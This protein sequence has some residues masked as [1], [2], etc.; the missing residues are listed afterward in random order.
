[1][2]SKDWSPVDAGDPVH[3]P[4]T[5]GCALLRFQ[6]APRP[7]PKTFGF[8]ELHGGDTRVRIVPALGGKIV[9]LQLLGREWL[10]TSDATEARTP[11]EG[12]SYV[13]TA[14]TGG[15]DECFPTV[16]P[17]QL[18]SG[19]AGYGGLSLPDHGELWTQGV[20]VAIETHPEGQRAVCDWAGQRMPYRFTRSVQV[21]PA[22]AV[23]MRYAVTNAGKGPL[24]F[25]W[26]AHPLFPLTPETRLDLPDGARVRV[27]SQH[28]NA[29]RG[30]AG[31]FRWPHARLEKRLADLAMPDALARQYACK[32]FLDM[33][34]GSSIAAIEEGDKRLEVAFDERQVP[35]VGIWLNKRGWTPFSRGK[36][37]LNLG[38]EPCIGAPDSLTDA[39][40]EWRGAQWLS[41]GE[42]RSW[43]LTWRARSLAVP[44]RKGDRH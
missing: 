41:P 38:L 15:Y 13:E 34:A 43:T 12:A 21:T 33:P 22:G 4:L 20:A 2:T 1:V 6:S 30:L 18:P 17:C 26:S 24:P 36:P 25:I 40:G 16:A 27:W 11:V 10:W 14:D 44:N 19:V 42:T 39:L 32:L 37:Y 8:A 29:L 7:A 3:R 31:E 28:G 23:A 9:S 35:N 5:L